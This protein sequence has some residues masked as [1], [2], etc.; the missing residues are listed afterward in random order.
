MA[1]LA[2]PPR[3]HI[4]LQERNARRREKVSPIE[5]CKELHSHAS[6]PD[7]FRSTWKSPSS[8]IPS[9]PRASDLGGQTFSAVRPHL[10]S[11]PPSP[12]VLLKS[13][14]LPAIRAEFSKPYPPGRL[15][16]GPL[17]FSVDF[18][19]ISGPG[20]SGLER[21]DEVGTQAIVSIN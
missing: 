2:P 17:T 9:A 7:S 12:L 20:S 21:N 4:L 1:G 18:R 5:T 13:D 11:P 3:P 16:P 14:K 19:G 6:A 8:R 10:F 15:G